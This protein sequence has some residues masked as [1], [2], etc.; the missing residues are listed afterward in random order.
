MGQNTK[1]PALLI[2]AAYLV[3]CAVMIVK[4]SDGQFSLFS[5]IAFGLLAIPIVGGAWIGRLFKA[6][7]IAILFYVA[8]VVIAVWV[9][10]EMWQSLFVLPPDAQ[11]AITLLVGPFYQMIMVGIAS[12]LA[13][14]IDSRVANR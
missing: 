3:A 11:S 13:W 7:W 2:S 4:V 12:I 8:V 9:Y 14:L 1:A 6:E 10:Y 5:L